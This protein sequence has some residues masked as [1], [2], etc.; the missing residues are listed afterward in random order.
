MRTG[1][2]GTYSLDKL[3]DGTYLVQ[4]DGKG[5]YFGEW[6]DNARTRERA[7]DVTVPKD[8]A[9]DGIDAVLEPAGGSPAP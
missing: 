9:V 8:G 4:F 7:T 5:D 6:Y 3:R 1:A 2:D